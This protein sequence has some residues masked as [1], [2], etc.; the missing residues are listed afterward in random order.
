MRLLKLLFK[1]E[2]FGPMLA[3]SFAS[4]VSVLLVIAR[5]VWSQ[6]IHYAF[7]IWNLFLAWLPLI[8]ALLACEQA[9][10][11]ARP[12][13]RFL[14][15]AGAWLLFFPNAP[16]I[17]TDMVHLRI[18]LSTH[19]YT[20][21]WVDLAMILICAL[22]G[23]IIGFVSLYLMQSVVRRMIG[24]VTSWLFIAAIAGL[25]SFGICVGRFLRFNSWDIVVKP[26]ELYESLSAWMES[27]AHPAS[28]AFPMLFAAFLFTAYLMLYALTH[29]SPVEPAAGPEDEA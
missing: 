16:Y 24:P 8:F 2:T 17:F 15:F 4:A 28:M 21:F 23:L 6:N 5:V 25:S 18:T 22:T 19:Q 11:G 27:L 10:A 9:K 13:W 20:L 29:L 12:G 7:L 26:G 14:G 1:P 3:M